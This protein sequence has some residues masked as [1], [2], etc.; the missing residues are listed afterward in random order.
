MFNFI[1]TFISYWKLTFSLDLFSKEK[2]ETNIEMILLKSS[3]SGYL[4]YD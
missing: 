2:I 4:M 1:N 3:N